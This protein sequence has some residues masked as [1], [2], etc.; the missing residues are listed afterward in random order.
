MNNI[1]RSSKNRLSAFVFDFDGTISVSDVSDI[2]LKQFTNSDWDSVGQSH[3]RGE[4]D[5]STMNQKFVSMLKASPEEIRL[6]L[7]NLTSIIRP[8]FDQIIS[9]LKKEEIPIFIISGG[10]DI[11]ISIVLKE[12]GYSNIQF[13]DD[14][15]AFDP[16]AFNI[17]CNRL[18]H[19]D[20]QWSI[21]DPQYTSFE[22]APSKPE[23]LKSLRKAISGRIA[24]AG[25]GTTDREA[26]K[27]VDLIY[28]T[29]GLA[30]FCDD[31]KIDFIRFESF[32][33]ILNDIRG[34]Q[35]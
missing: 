30:D 18:E 13:T 34:G 7:A 33:D 31:Q 26:I 15:T 25:D 22:S 28:A 8:G 19:T 35:E 21:L 14:L 10:W 11:Y 29:K 23:A 6:H 32:V 9:F 1:K 20:G 5:Y 4:I 16:L 24:F 17:V 27:Y 3:L 12:N 2:L